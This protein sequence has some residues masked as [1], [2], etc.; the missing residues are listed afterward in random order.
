MRVR[1]MWRIARFVARRY[2]QE[3][4]GPAWNAAAG[5]ASGAALMYWFDPDNGRRRR[6]LTR[7]QLVRGLHELRGSAVAA[8]DDLWHRAQGLWAELVTALEAEAAS[9]EVIAARVRSR[10]GFVCSH[11]GALEVMSH[12][13][14]VWL[15]GKI[16][17]DEV[18]RVAAAVRQV[19]GVRLV[20]HDFEVHAEAGHVPDLQGGH[21]RRGPRF[22]LLQRTW[23]PGPRLLAASAGVA[24][25]AYAPRLPPPVG[26]I[27]RL[28]GVGLT[29]RSLSNLPL[30]ELVGWPGVRSRGIDIT[31]TI[32]VNAPVEEVFSF[33]RSPENFPKF[34]SHLRAVRRLD[35]TRSHWE[36][37]G[38]LGLPVTIES[39]I[40]RFEPNQVI[41]W[42]SAPGSTLG[43]CG[44][45]HFEAADGAT[46]VQLDLAYRPPAG[47]VGHALAKLFGADPKRQLD[48]DMLRFKSLLEKGTATTHGH[49]V[50]L[51]EAEAP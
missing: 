18:E 45:A 25:V 49:K 9:D 46:R 28:I 35:D 33:W 36:I 19:R 41:A 20:K 17:A 4:A 2:G 24:A 43:M 50:T 48:S 3:R 29:L 31:K 10:L 47:A 12:D 13:G 30:G 11:P 27:S 32:N 5:A 14:S 7:D 1:R 26:W 22:E 51:G 38:P 16:L 34:M 21:R 42:E 40:T 44:I 39:V 23:S 15:T 8:R 6:A 37:G